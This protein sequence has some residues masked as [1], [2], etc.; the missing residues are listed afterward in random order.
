MFNFVRLQK[1]ADRIGLLDTSTIFALTAI[2]CIW[3]SLN[4]SIQIGLLNLLPTAIFL[5]IWYLFVKL[6]IPKKYRFISVFIGF[7]ITLR[8]PLTVAKFLEPLSCFFYLIIVGLL[9]YKIASYY[10]ANKNFVLLVA[11]SLILLFNSLTHIS[12]N[13]PYT[14]VNRSTIDLK[15]ECPYESPS[16]MVNC[17]FPHYIAEEKIFTDPE[18]DASF[19]VLL[20]RFFY[21][22]LSSLISFDGHRWIANFALNLLFWLF[23]CVALYKIV[24]LTQLG[25]RVAA[26]AML[27]CASSWGFVSFVGQPSMHMTAYAYASIL[28]WASLEMINS[29]S[30]PR[31]LLLA[32]II[33][34]GSLVYDIYA[35]ALAVL[36]LLLVYRKAIMAVLILSVQILS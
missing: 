29:Q 8:L 2:Q 1:G 23:A 4:I 6:E 34:S 13:S 21:G 28:L 19:S 7:L 20:R 24:V 25:D 3:M 14:Y 9:L 35:I 17:D 26:I 18:F 32:L 11:T 30:F 10:K 12:L 15:F 36:L 27:C 33:V 31:N 22:Y 5:S 16:F